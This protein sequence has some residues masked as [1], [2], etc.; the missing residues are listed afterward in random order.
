MHVASSRLIICVWP[1]ITN[2]KLHHVQIVEIVCMVMF[3][4]F[5]VSVP[6]Y[7]QA[8]VLTVLKVMHQASIFVSFFTFFEFSDVTYSLL[9]FCR[10]ITVDS[11]FKSWL[12]HPKNDRW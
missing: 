7:L 4:W 8:H 6:V 5:R 9:G 3:R 12:L 11:E 10:T 1:C 2:Q